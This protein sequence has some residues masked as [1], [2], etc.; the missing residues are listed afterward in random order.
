MFLSRRGA[1]C[2]DRAPR[3]DLLL[4]GRIGGQ[5]IDRS[6]LRAYPEQPRLVT[7]S[8]S[9]ARAARRAAGLGAGTSVAPLRLH[10]VERREESA[11]DDEP[12]WRFMDFT[13]YVSMLH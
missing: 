5:P 10:M 4:S 2:S 13:K 7:S 11:R 6:A 8:L 3:P 9:R 1:L 12:L